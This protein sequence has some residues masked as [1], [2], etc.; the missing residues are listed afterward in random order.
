MKD[1]DPDLRRSLRRL[2]SKDADPELGQNHGLNVTTAPPGETTAEREQPRL[3]TSHCLFKQPQPPLLLSA[4]DP[5]DALELSLVNGFKFNKGEVKVK[6][7]W[8]AAPHLPWQVDCSPYIFSPSV[9]WS[10][11]YATTITSPL[12]APRCPLTALVTFVLIGLHVFFP[13]Y[14]AYSSN[15]IAL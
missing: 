13:L 14:E 11:S 3:A 15:H 8:E 4:C 5:A 12:T 10:L 7:H 6:S 1:A 9:F 2:P